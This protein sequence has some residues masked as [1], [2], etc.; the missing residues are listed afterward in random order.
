MPPSLLHRSD[1]RQRGPRLAPPRPRRLLLELLERRCV[2]ATSIFIED[3][4]SDTDPSVAAFDSAADGFLID[5]EFNHPGTAGSVEIIDQGGAIGHALFFSN[6]TADFT[7]P[8]LDMSAQQIT[9]ASVDIALS[10]NLASEPLTAAV[11]FT[12]TVG[13]I[14][15]H[16]A[17]ALDSEI[18]NELTFHR[19]STTSDQLL[20]DGLP[21]G[22]ITSIRLVASELQAFVINDV[23]VTVDDSP[24]T[25]VPPRP[26]TDVIFVENF[27]FDDP[28]NPPS[29]MSD[30]PGFDSILDGFHIRHH[31]SGVA[32]IQKIDEIN[33]TGA[34]PGPGDASPP[35][36]LRLVRSLQ[37][38]TYTASIPGPGELGGLL[39]GEEVALAKVSVFGE[40]SVTFVGTAGRTSTVQISKVDGWQFISRA[41]AFVVDPGG[42]GEEDD[43]RLGG[44]REI[45]IVVTDFAYLDDVAVLIGTEQGTGPVRAFDNGITT[46]P[47]QPI[48][49]DVLANDLPATPNLL[50]ITS[51]TAPGNGTVQNLIFNIGYAP[52]PGF[53]GIDTFEYTVSDGAG[54]S[55]TA[56]VIVQVNTPPVA[57]D[58]VKLLPHGFAG[59]LSVAL[60]GVIANDPPD[61]DG[62]V[63]TARLVNDATRGTITLSPDGSYTY[64]PFGGGLVR[65][66]SFT[67]RSDDGFNESNLATVHILVE[68]EVPVAHHDFVR[69]APGPRAPDVEPD[70]T[71]VLANDTDADQDALTGVVMVDPPFHGAATPNADGT[72]TYEP[73]GF[74]SVFPGI[75]MFSY[76]A[77]D[78]ISQTNVAWV[79]VDVSHGA[80]VAYTDVYSVRPGGEVSNSVV[81]NDYS[82]GGRPLTISSVEDEHG[83]VFDTQYGTVA[84]FR[85]GGFHY[86]S[87]IDFEAVDSFTYRATNGSFETQLETVII[88]VMDEFPEV[89]HDRYE[90]APDSL[91]VMPAPGVLEN[92]PDPGIGISNF[93]TTNH[94]AL[95]FSPG[96]GSFTYRPVPGFYGIDSFFYNV[97]NGRGAESNPARVSIQVGQPPVAVT[98]LF[99]VP[100][101]GQSDL[102]VLGN[103]V[104]HG[105]VLTAVRTSGPE[106]TDNSLFFHHANGLKSALPFPDLD[107]DLPFTG[108]FD[109]VAPADFAGFDGFTYFASDGAFES[110]LAAVLIQVNAPPVAVDDPITIPPRSA[111]FIGGLLLNDHDPDG[112]AFTARLVTPPSHIILEDF[113]SSGGFRYQTN[114]FHGVDT[115]TYEVLDDLDVSRSPAVVTLIVNEPPIVV[116]DSREMRLLNQSIDPIGLRSERYLVSGPSI[117]VNDRDQDGDI[118]LISVLGPGTQGQITQV[119][120][121]GSMRYERVADGSNS[122]PPFSGQDTV[123]YSIHDGFVE[124]APANVRLTAVQNSTPVANDDV[125]DVLR[126][127][128]L[129][130]SLSVL[131]VIGGFVPTPPLG[132]I[133]IV[134][135]ADT[136]ADNDPLTATLVVDATHGSL[137]FQSDGRFTY[138]PDA[139]F[140]GDDTF[141]YQVSDGFLG[142]Q[143]NVATVTIH[144]GSPD[145]DGDHIDDHI[146]EAAPGGG[147]SN[148]D[149][150]QDSLQPHVASFHNF[151]N[152][153]DDRYVTL[154]G[155]AGSSL[156]N[157]RPESPPLDLPPSIFSLLDYFGF[158]LVGVI[159]GGA[160]T[161]DVL[162]NPAAF[163]NTYIKFGATPHDPETPEDDSVPH[164]Y[165]F[166]YDD[167]TTGAQFFNAGGQEIPPHSDGVVS[168]V[169]L[170]FVDGQRGD[171]DFHLGPNGRIVDPGGPAFVDLPPQVAS[172]ALNDGDVQRSKINSLTVTFDGLVTIDPGAFELRKVG[173]SAPV[174][175]NVALTDI[176]GRTVA[177]LTFHGAGV[178]YGSLADGEYRLLIRSAKIKSAAGSALDGDGDGEAGGDRVDEFFRRLAIRTATMMLICSTRRSSAGRWASVRTSPA[179]CGTWTTTP[180]A[181]SG[182]KTW[183]CSCSAT[184]AA[185]GG[186][187]RRLGPDRERPPR[188][189]VVEICA[190]VATI[191]CLAR[192]S[193]WQKRGS[194]RQPVPWT[195]PSS[196]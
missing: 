85:S 28:T 101:G 38:A 166:L 100:N 152:P 184:F 107:F 51:V 135:G 160:V 177:H 124:S 57:V 92:D 18:G 151:Q 97:S 126:N 192:P 75:D 142:G 24:P 167:G 76:R 34:R 108:V 162:L 134:A 109:Y 29:F 105:R 8:L 31:I 123:T 35:H 168:R 138:T 154:V 25:N 170:H 132:G 49:I 180:T 12:S 16:F 193:A 190:T 110:E 196:S 95:F 139:G 195:T 11:L 10:S 9:A 186:G 54:N 59:D 144:V 169:V 42:P 13:G 137:S 71:Q 148:G 33:E 17:A 128:V 56:R 3:F 48:V 125:Y 7:F 73:S 173:A 93:S 114:G 103:D 149:G 74:I 158:D 140:V 99:R 40:G 44:I 4:T 77:S 45:I 21:L 69:V 23:S 78:G 94:G 176:D 19:L 183:S 141:Q 47:G 37:P 27:S 171:A 117:L 178:H 164:W 118:P 91:L 26:I 129:N 63:V 121:D 55:D 179:T 22:P 84:L 102:D 194:L 188:K 104:D 87:T 146:E 106:L 116:D 175:L 136:D 53:H 130:V 165:D 122:L 50:R 62:D 181:A 82:P 30:Q 159:P 172:V 145:T 14:S 90:I 191:G 46:P 64:S 182:S 36:V 153:F 113:D 98:D 61:A 41:S 155:P 80:P 174:M 111:G 70:R 68:N 52:N 143:S 115:F 60:P 79:T 150:V 163:A 72:I 119:F 20:A 81:S 89:A 58:D 6:G 157:V 127:S 147:D 185:A 67:Y 66:D 96:D 88:Y 133:G 131:G 156:I 5:H 65:P 83:D 43:I 120:E 86:G 32:R 1:R 39:P 161:V 15:R 189:N 2:L 187:S 112:D